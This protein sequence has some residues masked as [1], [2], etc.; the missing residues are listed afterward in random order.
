[1]TRFAIF[2]TSWGPFTVVVSQRGLVGTL[3]P[4]RSAK[5]MERFVIERWPDARPNVAGLGRFIRETKDYFAGRRHRRPFAHDM[6]IDLPGFT[7]FRRDVLEAARR[8]PYG[9]TAAYADLARA[10]GRPLAMRAV[11]ST[12]AH[13]PL[14]LVVPCHRIVRADGT[15]GGFSCR[16]GVSMKCRLLALEGIADFGASGTPSRR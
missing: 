1:M 5:Q 3:L 15:L 8:V 4:D 11:G 2:E 16:E 7:D 9:K 14:P 13:N 10:A 6:P 12:M